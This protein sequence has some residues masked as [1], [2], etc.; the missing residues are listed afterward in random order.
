MTF[1]LCEVLSFGC[2]DTKN[3]ANKAKNA[4]I[5]LPVLIEK[6]IYR[7]KVAF[8]VMSQQEQDTLWHSWLA[9][10]VIGA[11]SQNNCSFSL[12][13]QINFVS[14]QRIKLYEEMD[15]ISSSANRVRL[16]PLG[17][18]DFGLVIKQGCYY[19][20][21]TMFIPRLEM[22]SNYLFLVRPRR[23]GKSLLLSMLKSYYDISE[24]GRFDEYF[25]RLWI[26]SHPTPYRN[27]YAVL[28]L[29]FSQVT[30]TIDSLEENFYG[31]CNYAL[32]TFADKYQ[33]L[34]GADFTTVI[35]ADSNATL[36]CKCSFF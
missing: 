8:F 33:Q 9:K 23:F 5:F 31:Y 30:G 13:T 17:I 11:F 25:G 14:L 35:K 32:N 28:H 19:V 34:F 1:R 22:A 6:S 7:Q 29:D 2:K 21:K 3:Y 12:A 24:K 20:D 26:G 36:L 27:R 18:S 16:L 4:K 10:G 15:T